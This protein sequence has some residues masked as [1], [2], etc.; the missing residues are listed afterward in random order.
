MEYEVSIVNELSDSSLD[1]SS[2]S[3]DFAT[4]PS[5]DCIEREIFGAPAMFSEKPMH[6]ICFNFLF[7]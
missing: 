6:Q 7:A 1:S 3:F 2:I 5:Y 4:H